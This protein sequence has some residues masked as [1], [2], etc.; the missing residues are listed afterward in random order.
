MPDTEHF[1]LSI[2][3]GTAGLW[4]VTGSIHRGLLVTG[5]SLGEALSKVP[6][7]LAELQH[8]EQE[9]ARAGQKG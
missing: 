2:E 8:A 9:N 3:K 6:D 7:A 4:Y 5:C 1:Y